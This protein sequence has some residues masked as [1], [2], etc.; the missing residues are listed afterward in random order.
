MDNVNWSTEKPTEAGFYW[1]WFG[2]DILDPEVVEI[3][4]DFEN[5]GG[6][7]VLQIGVEGGVSLE[8]YQDAF[9]AP[10][11]SHPPMKINDGAPDVGC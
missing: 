6:L 9:W 11:S 5:D 3:Q 2:D 8:K 7:E 10:V 4:D 1:L